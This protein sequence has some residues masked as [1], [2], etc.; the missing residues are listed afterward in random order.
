MRRGQLA[1]R[2]MSNVLNEEKQQAI[3]GLGRLVWSLR[4]IEQRTG[5]RRRETASAHLKAAGGRG[6]WGR[7]ETS[8]PTTPHHRFE[9][10][11]TGQ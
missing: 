9:R 5:V 6:R 11:K 10:G 8:S 2:A 7:R 1:L 3:L 4:R